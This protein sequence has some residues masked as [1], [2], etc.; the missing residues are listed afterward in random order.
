MEISAEILAALLPAAGAAAAV[1][2]NLNT[3]IAT[4]AQRLQHLEQERD[5]MRSLMKEV[6]QA[7]EEI[8]VLIAQG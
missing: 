7:I 8:R 4:M 2:I 6:R 1:W 5:E 3:K